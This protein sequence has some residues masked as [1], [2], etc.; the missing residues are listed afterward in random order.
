MTTI[1]LIPAKRISTRLPG[2][3]MLPFAGVSMLAHKIVTLKA[4]GR[5]DRIIVGSDAPAILAEAQRYGA[6]TLQR[7]AFHCDESQCSANQMIHDM[8]SRVGGDL[9][10]W[11]H[12]T[13]PL[14]KPITY[15]RAILGYEKAVLLGYDSLVSVT[16]CRRHAWVHRQPSN[17][18]PWSGEHVVG[19][20]LEPVYLQDGAIFIQPR[21]Q[22]VSNRYFYGK[23]PALFEIPAH[24]GTDIDTAEDYAVALALVGRV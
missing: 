6:E 18:D 10:V 11:A 16:P 8:A 23:N 14:V 17:F 19:D 9:I 3:N 12:C 21:E 4:C 2:K 20:K 24:E 22:M 1:A 15:D 5:I 13:N 7:D